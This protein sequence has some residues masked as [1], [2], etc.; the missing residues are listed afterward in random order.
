[1]NNFNLRFVVDIKEGH[2][3]HKLGRRKE[4]KHDNTSIFIV[5]GT[6]CIRLLNNQ[7]VSERAAVFPFR[8]GLTGFAHTWA[9][10][11]A[12]IVRSSEICVSTSLFAS[13]ISSIKESWCAAFS[14]SRRQ[15]QSKASPFVLDV[16]SRS[17][18]ISIGVNIKSNSR[19]HA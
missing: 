16:L 12:S 10:W 13:R 18:R 6:R 8:S 1:M 5:V 17:K 4:V 15:T 9:G 3:V 11:G 7:H 2:F 14:T 19:V